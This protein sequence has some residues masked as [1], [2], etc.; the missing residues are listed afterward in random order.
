MVWIQLTKLIL[1]QQMFQNGSV[2]ANRLKPLVILCKT[3][4]WKYPKH[5][6]EWG[7]LKIFQQRSQE[8]K[9]GRETTYLDVLKT[10]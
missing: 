5:Q 8:F 4:F 1:N 9:F 7:Q 2:K 6:M 10:L 3:N